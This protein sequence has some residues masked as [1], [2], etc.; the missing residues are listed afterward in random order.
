MATAETGDIEQRGINVVRGLAMDAV[1]KANSGHPGTPMALAPL[2]HVL[3]TR[4]MKYDAAAPEW[5]DRDRFVLSAG[6][7]SMLLYSYLYLLGFG[8]ELDDLRDFRQ[9]G[10][11]TPGHPEYRHTAGVEVTT[12]PLGQGVANGVGIALAEANLRDRFGPAVTDH[13]VFGICGD[14]DL[15]EGVSHEAASIA[16][17][18]GL[19]RLVYVYDDNHITIDGPTEL[20][21]TDD[22]R[23]RFEGYGWHV[24][25]IGEVAN[26]LA[27]L[28]AGIREGMAE[29]ARPSLVVLRSHIGYPSPQFT[30]SPKAHGNPLGAD[31]IAA[32]KEI[33]GLPADQSFFVPDDVLAYYRGAGAT[34]T[35]AREAW[36]ARRAA[37]RAGEP[38]MAAEYDACLEGR[39]LA[40]WEAKLPVFEP[41]E[42]LATRQA[43]AKIVN[44]VIDVVPGLVCGGADLTEN[45]GMELQ[46]GGVIDRHRFGGR[47]VHYG[48]REHGMG[49]VMNGMAVSGL[50][51]AGG[52]FFV[53]SDYMRPAARLAALSGYKTAFVWTHD[54]VGLGED[55]P[56]HQPVEQLASFRAMP[57]LRVIRPADANEVSQAW[58]VH[59]DGD[60]PTAFILSRQK[61]PVLAGTAERAPEG[62][63]KGAYTLVDEPRG[64][65]DLVLI[66]TGSEVA[67]C[68]AAAEALAA[69]GIGARV[70]S[71]PSWDLFAAQREDYRAAVL[72][73]GIPRLAVEA[74]T[75]FGWER[76]SDAVVG[77]DHFGS[78]APGDRVLAEFGI[79][80]V[81]VADHA[82]ALVA[83]ASR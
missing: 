1:Q 58:R 26:D 67:V 42:S 28:E 33:L 52:T 15:Q 37:F 5:P 64:D 29:T 31:E 76:Y 23:K 27:A 73:A 60:G 17:H 79:T 77:F 56:T 11:H 83:G 32:V 80:P 71:M 47:Q 81:N 72:P 35:P 46:S 69:D 54:S 44:A 8:L 82:R 9:W 49:S 51:P 2:A 38:E 20:S 25:E 59:V 24:H 68:V 63:P 19:G 3:F 62:L 78:S 66:G 30:D 43:C 12:G 75:T 57:G 7:A 74:G 4:V 10:S 34:G 53:F 70:V 39:G 41:G 40:G 45:T 50:L 18:L 65:L 21:Y 55:G 14:G 61:L 6:H 22:V 48:I 13:H 16:G 36:E